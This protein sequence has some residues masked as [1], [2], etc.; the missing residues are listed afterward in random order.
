MLSEEGSFGLRR[1]VSTLRK[2]NT[3]NESRRSMKIQQFKKLC[4]QGALACILLAISPAYAQQTYTVTTT[5]D[6]VP[7]TTNSLRWAIEQV[8]AGAGL[9]DTI[10]FGIPTSDSGYDPATNTW[11]IVPVQDLDTITQKVTIDGYTQSNAAL[12]I[13]LNGNNYMTGDGNMTGNGLHFAPLS[14]TSVDGSVVRGLIINQWIDNGILLDTTNNN[15]TGVSIVGNFMGTDAS[16]TQQMAN[17]NAIGLAGINGNQC[18]STMIGTT[19]AADRN[20]LAGSFSGNVVDFY[21]LE[22]GCISSTRNLDTVIQNNYIGTDKT[23][24]KALGNMTHGLQL[25]VDVGDIITGNLISGSTVNGVYLTACGNTLIEGNY[26][27]TDITG[28]YALGNAN[29]G[30]RTREAFPANA[31]SGATIVGNVI[32]GNGAGIHIGD[33]A[34]PGSIFN[35]VQSNFIGTNKKGTHAIPNTRWGIE[36]AD[37]ENTIGGSELTQANFISGNLK[38]GILVYSNNATANVISNNLVGTDSTG[39]FPLPNNKNGIQIGLNGGLGGSF[40]NLIGDPS[41]QSVLEKRP[42]GLNANERPRR[43]RKRHKL[44]GASG[45]LPSRVVF[46]KPEI[47]KATKQMLSQPA[48]TIGL[49]F[50]A[51][52]ISDVLDA[53]AVLPNQN[54]WVG[55]QQY[56]LMT[57]GIIRS[58]NKTTGQPD[59]ALDID[60]ASFFGLGV[61][62]DVR[63]NYSR[64]LDRWI[65]SCESNA[66]SE[67]EV[68]WSDS[69][70]ITP[71]YS[72]DI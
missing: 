68:A 16:G 22:G 27:G 41:S 32:S 34:R 23:G 42:L 58:F 1:K 35:T 8:N 5:A 70:V 48:Q 26:I 24:T 60:A 47:D 7:A 40:G 65:F 55:P 46:S 45:S 54:G 21:G 6:T 36:L 39:L 38:G 50:T 44:N 67:L 59:G 52:T 31:T 3:Q 19:A 18:I 14:D 56:I 30:I 69:G 10:A 51:A 20:I 62:S 11:T 4:T 49:N 37:S 57:Y 13:I 63:I 53:N 15:I 12:T 72:L 9:G 43:S 2:Q 29:S 64:F 25:R 17:R 28:T 66:D 33:P 61:H 71:E